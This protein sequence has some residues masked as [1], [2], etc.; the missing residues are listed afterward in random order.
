MIALGDCLFDGKIHR[1]ALIDCS[2]NGRLD[3]PPVQAMA[4][5][6]ADRVIGF[7]AGD[8]ILVDVGDGS[9]SRCLQGFP[10]CPIYV[11]GRPYRVHPTADG[12]GVV[13]EAFATEM[14]KLKIAKPSWKATLVGKKYCMIVSGGKDPVPLPDDTYAATE[15]QEWFT[16]TA[17]D[18]GGYVRTQYE[19]ERIVVAAG[20]T[21]EVRHVGLPVAGKVV[22]DIFNTQHRFFIQWSD[23]SGRQIL[24]VQPPGP[25]V[26]ELIDAQGTIVRTVKS[27][28][29]V[30]LWKPPEEI[31]GTYKVRLSPGLEGC[32]VEPGEITFK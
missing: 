9:F 15:F 17:D 6:Y 25:M 31:K 5:N 23:P 14:G 8:Y 4:S 27:D 12:E 7:K 13:A 10:Q 22:H 3:D 29:T 32:K 20:Q 18:G 21:T 19:P 1:V 11:E 24:N 26:M 30:V 2:S 28:M 16:E